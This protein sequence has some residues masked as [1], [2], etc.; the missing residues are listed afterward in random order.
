MNDE[1]C[2]C[3]DV[4]TA[5]Q[6]L[7]AIYDQAMVS[8]GVSVNQFSLL[9]LI[10]SLEGPTLKG[11]AS[12]SGLDRSTLGRNMRVLEKLG[13]VTMHIGDDARVRNV[14]MTS[15]GIAAFKLAV[16][17]WREVQSRLANK[18]GSAQHVQFKETLQ[19]LTSSA[20]TA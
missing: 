14:R 5:A 17:L 10:Y 18:I 12:A 4:R 13:F 8:S 11:L 16:P 15:K 1:T 3:I 20:M 9:H 2:I 7:T 6:R 19:T